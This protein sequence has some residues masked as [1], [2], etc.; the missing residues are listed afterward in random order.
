MVKCHV[1]RGSRSSGGQRAF[2]VL[3]KIWPGARRCVALLWELGRL[4]EFVH[5]LIKIMEENILHN[6]GGGKSNSGRGGHRTSV[7]ERETSA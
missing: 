5:V 4:L 2:D 1:A 3:S 7:V 6:Q